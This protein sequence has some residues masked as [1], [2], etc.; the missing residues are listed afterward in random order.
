MLT[1]ILSFSELSINDVMVPRA[2]IEALDSALPLKEVVERFKETSHSRLP[3]YEETL[4]NVV[5][6]FHIKDLIN[7]WND[8]DLWGRMFDGALDQLNDDGLFVITSYFDKEHD[9]ACQKLAGLGAV[10]IAEH[11]NPL[12]RVSLIRVQHGHH[13]LTDFGINQRPCT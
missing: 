4:D 6:M 3:V 9:L 2:D 5:G 10:K 12:S 8:P 11:R 1:N 13:N 7:F